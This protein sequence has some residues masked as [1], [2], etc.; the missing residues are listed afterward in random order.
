MATGLSSLADAYHPQL[1]KLRQR[2]EGLVPERAAAAKEALANLSA[3]LD[4]VSANVPPYNGTWV[5]DLEAH[6]SVLGA[7][8]GGCGHR[9]EPPPALDRARRIRQACPG[10]HRGS[11]G[12]L[13][14]WPLS[15]PCL[16]T[17]GQGSPDPC[18]TQVGALPCR[19]GV[20]AEVV[21]CGPTWGACAWSCMQAI[22]TAA[23][24]GSASCGTS[25]AGKVRSPL[26]ASMSAGIGLPRWTRPRPLLRT[27]G[28]RCGPGR[29][30]GTRVPT[31]PRQRI[32][33]RVDAAMCQDAEDA[34]A[35]LMATAGHPTLR[36]EA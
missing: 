20:A 4:N 9:A 32:V 24:S 35:A 21:S 7:G 18:R 16:P 6:E 17:G 8:D 33:A 22:R 29:A 13:S 28:L 15:P 31:A 10:D 26:S 23:A 27:P 14:H 1:V 34:M 36:A 30:I 2:L 25:M 5:V 11:G 3:L 12:G 19:H